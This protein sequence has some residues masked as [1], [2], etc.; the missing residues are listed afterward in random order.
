MWT[1]AGELSEENRLDVED[2]FPRAILF[3]DTGVAGIKAH[4]LD[5]AI[6]S[7]QKRNIARPVVS[8]RPLQ[9]SFP[10]RVVAARVAVKRTKQLPRALNFCLPPTVTAQVIA[11]CTGVVPGGFA[12]LLQ[13]VL[14]VKVAG[15]P[16]YRNKRLMGDAF[17]KPIVMSFLVSVK[18]DTTL[19]SSTLPLIGNDKDC[20][21][22]RFFEKYIKDEFVKL[23]PDPAE[24]NSTHHQADIVE[25]LFEL[26]RTKKKGGVIIAFIITELFKLVGLQRV[27]DKVKNLC[28]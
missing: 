24:Y 4:L 13:D 18:E 10:I 16:E 3:H 14:K 19:E 22:P 25:V 2:K 26:S 5:H 28:A 1:H 15:G 21:M 11:G 17:L 23:F 8:P 7:P 9:T 6:F 27:V 20:A 12:Q